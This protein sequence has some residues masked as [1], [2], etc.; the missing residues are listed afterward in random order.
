[1]VSTIHHALAYSH[2]QTSFN[3]PVAKLLEL[4]MEGLLEFPFSLKSNSIFEGIDD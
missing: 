1:M 3:L 4:L 2:P